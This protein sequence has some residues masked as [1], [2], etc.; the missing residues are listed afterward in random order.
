M[1]LY[2]ALFGTNPFS[3]MLLQV[4]GTTNGAVPR[5]RDCYLN[6]DGDIV[7]HTRT[8]GGNREYYDEPNEENTDG[9][10]NST[11]RALPGFKFDADDDFD[12]TYADFH[13]SVPEA[14]KE[15]I[16]LLKDLGAVSNPAE[17]WQSLLENMRKGDTSSPETQR[18]LA[19]GEQIFGQIKSALDKGDGGI[20]KV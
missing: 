7:I 3:S 14:F 13:Y 2:N 18:A 20:I 9:P 16:A 17:R 1:S 12:S 15:Q 19:V 10:W 4:L 11:L 5:F 8:G 6:E